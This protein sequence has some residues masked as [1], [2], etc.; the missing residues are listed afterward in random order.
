VREAKREERDDPA[1]PVAVDNS[2]RKLASVFE[3]PE[4][5]EDSRDAALER[6]DEPWLST[7]LM[8]DWPDAM[9]LE[10]PEETA[11]EAEDAE[12]P[13]WAVA[14]PLRAETKTTE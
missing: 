5:A 6:T 14:R 9:A 1:D 13:A 12:E 2:E 3:R 11:L 10:M 8:T 7:E 4:R